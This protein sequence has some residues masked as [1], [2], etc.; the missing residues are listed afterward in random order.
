M[1]DKDKRIKVRTSLPSLQDKVQ[2]KITGPTDTIYWYI[3]FNIPL[4]EESVSG[5]TM[6]VTD[7]DGY[8]MRTVIGYRPKH[9]A[10]SVSPLDTYEENRFYLLNISRMVRSAKGQHLRS[11][12]HI[13]FKL[14]ANQVSDFR[15]LDKDVQ[16]PTPIPR[17][18][19]YDVRPKDTTPNY[20]EQQYIN[21]SPPGKMTTVSFSFNPV[22]GIIGLV[23]AI[24]GI[25]LSHVVTGVLGSLI[26]MAGI[27]HIFVQLRDDET[28]STLLFNRGVRQFNR[29]QYRQAGQT[30]KRSLAANPDNDL[31]KYGIRK[32]EIYS[33]Y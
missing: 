23:V 20:F 13:L 14:F 27:V 26:C 3:I 31:A 28:R 33:R 2:T 16:V 15:V 10:I 1:S 19:D 32:A 4:D 7:T 22:V 6:N 12:I 25:I 5:K 17:P 30:F 18:V 24:I 9:N 11:T 8:I 29:E 21:N